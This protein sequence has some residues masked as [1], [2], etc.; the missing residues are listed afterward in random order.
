MKSS[1]FTTLNTDLILT[2]SHTHTRTHTHKITNTHTNIQAHTQKVIYCSL[3]VEGIVRKKYASS[4]FFIRLL[5][6]HTQTHTRTHIH[7][8]KGN[9]KE[10]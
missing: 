8:R 1:L 5:H 7:T 9:N 4:T 2:L 3:M 10:W 6:K